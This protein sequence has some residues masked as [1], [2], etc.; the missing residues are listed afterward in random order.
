M[1]KNHKKDNM[2]EGSF[3][4]PECHLEKSD[5]DKRILIG[6]YCRATFFSIYV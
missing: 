2:G 4:K 3:N 1:K 6:N 5:N